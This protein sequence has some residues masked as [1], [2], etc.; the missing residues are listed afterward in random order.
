[1]AT[2]GFTRGPEAIDAQLRMAHDR[3]AKAISNRDRALLNIDVARHNARV[4][5][6]TVDA[7]NHCIDS[8]LDAKMEAQ[9]KARLEEMVGG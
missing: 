1:M 8:L 2:D 9:D 6:E 4:H 5:Q 7:E 3:R